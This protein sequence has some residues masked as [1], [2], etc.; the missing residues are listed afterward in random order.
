MKKNTFIKFLAS[1]RL[2]VTLFALAFVLIFFGTL[3]QVEM[4][5]WEAVA[6]YFRSPVA[7]LDPGLAIPGFTSPDW[8]RIPIPGGAT[9]AFL[10][11]I[12]LLAA[13]LLKFRLSLAKAGI[14]ILH[15]GVIVLLLGELVTGAF[16]KEGLMRID[17]GGSSSFVE[18]L[19]SAELAIID[20][21]NP[22]YDK[23]TS[24]PAHLIEDAA[25]SGELVEHSTVPFQIEV[26]E[27]YPNARLL[28]ANADSATD[29]G[30]GREAMAQ[31]VQKVSGTS[32]GK[33]DAPAAYVRLLR[34]GQAMGTWML[35]A[36]LLDAQEVTVGEKTYGIALRFTRTYKPYRLDLLEF[37]HDKFTGT[38]IARN[39]SSRVRLVDEDHGTDREVTI[40]MN[41]PLRYQGSTFYQ[42]SY[43]PDG[44][45]TVLQV[46]E[47]PGAWLPYI[48][49][50][51]VGGGMTFHFLYVLTGF[52]QRRK[53]R[54]QKHVAGDSAQTEASA[55]RPIK[56]YVV[57]AIFV[58]FALLIAGFNL[59]SSPDQ[60]EYN[61]HEFAQIP[62]SAGGR[63]KPM[64]TA[65][66]HLVSVSS[67]K[68]SIRDNGE[69]ISAIEY[70]I[71]LVAKPE[72]IKGTP[73]LRVDHPDVLA[74]MEFRPEDAGKLDFNT[75]E[76]HWD[77]IQLQA[78]LASQVDRQER[79]GYQ[80]AVLK[81]HSQ[82]MELLS[83]A[84]L[85]QPYSIPPTS[86]D[87]EW[88]SFTS[89]FQ[90]GATLERTHPA[91]AY[92]AAMFT[93]W[94]EQDTERFNSAVSNYIGL[95]ERDMSSVMDRSRLE[96]LYNRAKG[97]Q[98]AMVVYTLAFLVI[99]GGLLTNLKNNGRASQYFGFESLRRSGTALIW[100]A[101]LIH[102][103]TLIIR[104][105]LQDRPPVTNLYSSAIF[106]GWAAV[107]TGLILEH[108][109]R[110]GIAA[111]GS[112]TIG[113]STLVVA[114]NLG[115][116]GDTMEM[117]Q[118]VL[119]SNFWLATHVITITLGYSATFLAGTLAAVYLIWSVL[120]KTGI[121]S[122]TKKS[123]FGMVYGTVCFALLL[124]FIGTVLGGIW[125]DQS[126]GRFWGWDPKENGAAL[127]V[128]I[129][130]IIL[131][132][133]WGGIIRERG[134]MVLAVFG[135]IVTAWSWFG[136][137]ML[138]VG[139]HSYGFMNS[140]VMWMSIFVISQLAIMCLGFFISINKTKPLD[141]PDKLGIIER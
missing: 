126:W 18:D 135:N 122:E 40:W 102:T 6:T 77:K 86:A 33:S 9:I 84:A 131:H 63:I 119:D 28:V 115:T 51:L 39:F 7:M 139:L 89:E 36:D 85:E 59:L 120:R 37:N 116:D 93:A 19:R 66:R 13:H 138:G 90:Q 4:G 31:P 49:S 130:A 94:N 97:F 22:D 80:R 29:R 114:H 45:G 91:V 12:N 107:L 1:L 16:S 112:A 10:M 17:V 127:I 43:K 88:A 32:G 124:S 53:L 92:Q 96:I 57:P 133:R 72:A 128:L 101:F 23:V 123:L 61:L 44:S 3:A 14:L 11:I 58:T 62:V 69:K 27:W 50:A 125:A 75:I 95:L 55:F 118:A 2:T 5:V 46:V 70:L 42:A 20:T 132:A 140:A 24:I 82:V 76:S 103:V 87:G 52:L 56:H 104:I 73:I 106:V 21:S 113:F 48:A 54:E 15:A 38:E 134:V 35:S 74:L 99:C 117:M 111:L 141:K 68:Q 81:L 65:A 25:A 129:T 121:K 98:G 30:I 105:Y 8:F 110:L 47:N 108:F 34:D 64:D 67:G 26:L 83:H 79:D 137:N 60:S 109:H 78:Q 41:N 136:T 100:T 71:D